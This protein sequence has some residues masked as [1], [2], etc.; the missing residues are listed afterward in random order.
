MEVGVMEGGELVEHGQ[1]M[2]GDT[3][4]SGSYFEG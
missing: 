3:E 4:K 1:M 2:R